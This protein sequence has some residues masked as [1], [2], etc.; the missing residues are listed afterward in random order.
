MKLYIEYI[1]VSKRE[2]NNITLKENDLNKEPTTN[3][4]AI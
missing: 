2:N 3:I 4:V 1:D